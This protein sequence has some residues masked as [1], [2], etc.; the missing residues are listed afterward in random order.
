MEVTEADVASAR[1]KIETAHQRIL[2]GEPFSLVASEV[3]ADPVSAQRGGQ[4]GR[5]RL[6][7]LSNQF[8]EALREKGAGEITEPLLTPAGF[9]IFL[10]QERSYGRKLTF[11]EVKDS[12]RRL[13]E[14]EKLEAELARYVESLRN[15]FFIDL[16][17]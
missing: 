15:R 4:L 9:Y 16:K 5:F 10:V 8:Q 6:E 14:S 11:A 2:A 13:L 7:D 12:I 3:S 17:G 1:Q